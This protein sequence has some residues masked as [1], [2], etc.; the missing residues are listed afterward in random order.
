MHTGYGVGGGTGASLG[1]SLLFC[2]GLGNGGFLG[3][4]ALGLGLCKGGLA[5]S[6]GLCGKSTPWPANADRMRNY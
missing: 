5:F 4:L 2:D 6:L 1:F 3:S